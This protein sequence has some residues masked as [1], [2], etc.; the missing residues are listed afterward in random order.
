MDV[1]ICLYKGE[2][3]RR[4]LRL[5]RGCAYHGSSASFYYDGD[6]QVNS[7]FH[8]WM[9]GL[10]TAY[11]EAVLCGTAMSQSTPSIIERTHIDRFIRKNPGGPWF[12]SV[13]SPGH[14]M[15]A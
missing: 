5:T 11:P 14:G 7:D 4:T 6:G 9:I 12:L 13:C 8:T 15:P 2:R 10:K 1:E 3:P